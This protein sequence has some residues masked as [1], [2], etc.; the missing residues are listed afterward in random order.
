MSVWST[1]LF[2]TI[3]FLVLGGLQFL[4]FITFRKFVKAKFNDKNPWK[5]ISIYPFILFNIP[6]LYLLFFRRSAGDVS[7]LVYDMVFIPFYIFLGAVIFIGLYLLIGKLI[8]LPF[9]IFYWILSR[10]KSIKEK[11]SVIAK[12]PEVKKI[13]QSRRAFLRTSAFLVS[14]YAFTGSTLGVLR[15]DN[16]DVTNIDIKINNLPPELKGTTIT[17]IADIHSGPFMKEGLMHEYAEAINNLKSDIILIPGDITNSNKEEVFPFIK[18]FKDLK[19]PH[20]IYAS[21][22]N[23][24]Y[25]SD[26]NFIADALNSKSPVKLLR[27]DTSII[28]I[29]NKEIAIL[30]VEDTRKSNAAYDPVLMSYV[31]QTIENARKKS[32]EKNLD[33]ETVPKIALIHKPYF[34]DFMQD[35]KLDLI[36]SGHTHGGQVVLAKFGDVNIS[37]AGAVSKYISGFYRGSNSSMY[38][39]RGIGNVGLPIRMNCPPEIT[40]ITLV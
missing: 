2:F 32:V 37:F 35:R 3:V 11:F 38:V 18:A 15:S 29:K 26:P 14:G 23:H 7:P 22:G 6:F 24:D 20:G 33:F 34:F 39:S 25:F 17:M 12:K 5:A 9:L 16:Y 8:K 27:N 10:F 19:A 31:D 1:I 30:G 4:V 28:T 36:L 21:L 13:D 40:K